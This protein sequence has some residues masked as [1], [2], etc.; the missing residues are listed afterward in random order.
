M[1]A[2]PLLALLTGHLLSEVQLIHKRAAEI[3]RFT[4]QV[5][6]PVGIVA[7]VIVSKNPS[8]TLKETVTFIA[9]LYSLYF[10]FAPKFKVTYLVVLIST[11]MLIFRAFYSSYYYPIAQLKYPPV[12]E[13]A[14]QIAQ[15]SQGFELYTKTK[16][17]QLCFYVETARDQILPFSPNPPPEALFLSQKR[18]GYV[19]KEY[20]LGKRRFYLCSYGIKSLPP[21]KRD[22]GELQQQSRERQSH[23]K[24]KGESL[25]G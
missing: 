12:R 4:I 25:Q 2:L 14:R 13:T 8:L 5:L 19:L 18:E 1:P 7:G 24:E 10:F 3:L 17:L 11:L 23:S 20:K 16:Y 22:K 21:G 6:V 9:F 15:D